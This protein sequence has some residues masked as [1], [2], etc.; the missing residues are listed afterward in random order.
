MPWGSELSLTMPVPVKDG[1]LVRGSN[2]V[3][4][5]GVE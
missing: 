2:T 4:D 5:G 3:V 1:Q